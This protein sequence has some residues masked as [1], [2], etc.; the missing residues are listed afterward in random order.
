MILYATSRNKGT[1]CVYTCFSLLNPKSQKSVLYIDF[2]TETVKQS[3]YKMERS[4][5]EQSDYVQ[6]DCKPLGLKVVLE[7]T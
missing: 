5:L 6:S 1:T 2:Y 4:G 3:A 7:R